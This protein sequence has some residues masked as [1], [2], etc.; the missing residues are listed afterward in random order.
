MIPACFE[1]SI[2]KNGLA[3]LDAYTKLCAFIGIVGYY[4]HLYIPAYAALI[5][6]I[7]QEKAFLTDDIVNQV[8]ELVIYYASKLIP[9][10][11]PW[12]YIIDE[13]IKSAAANICVYILALAKVHNNRNI[14]TPS[15]N[16]CINPSEIPPRFY[17]LIFRYCQT[18]RTEEFNL[19]ELNISL[20]ETFGAMG[21]KRGRISKAVSE[22]NPHYRHGAG[23]VSDP[24]LWLA[25]TL[26]NVELKDQV[27]P[28]FALPGPLAN[29]Y[30]IDKS[31]VAVAELMHKIISNNFIVSIQSKNYL[32]CL[33]LLRGRDFNVKNI[34][35]AGAED[36]AQLL[37][38]ACAVGYT[39]AIQMLLP[40]IE[41]SNI[42][43]TVCSNIFYDVNSLFIMPQVLAKYYY[44]NMWH[45]GYQ[46]D[47]H[48]R[49]SEYNKIEYGTSYILKADDFGDRDG[50]D[51]SLE[52]LF[53]GDRKGVT[54]YPEIHVRDI[55]EKLLIQTYGEVVTS[56]NLGL[57][58]EKSLMDKY[59]IINNQVLVEY[60]RF[61]AFIDSK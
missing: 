25:P 60:N 26:I 17:N 59:T 6:A 32:E 52:R 21:A 43:K 18:L 40:L 9:T 49:I 16:L 30:Y 31:I 33:N 57:T 44:A 29:L 41:T 7:R 51:L 20:A 54:P 8:P 35:N 53:R 50:F 13:A 14:F 15:L 55:D 34:I 38:Y 19:F 23:I 11:T 48:L 36:Y 12:Y 37:I 4:A 5:F 39:G 22:S 24:F 2:N 42:I 45:L 47:Y 3:P 27:L 46:I 58:V 1:S 28:P 56:Q 10:E 61:L